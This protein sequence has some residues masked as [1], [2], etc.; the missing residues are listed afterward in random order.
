MLNWI[1]I[2]QSMKMRETSRAADK[3]LQ[4]NNYLEYLIE[5]LHIHGE[6]HPETG[7]K[8]KVK[9]FQFKNVLEIMDPI[10]K[11]VEKK[12]MKPFMIT[13]L[14]TAFERDSIILSPFDETIYKQLID[15]NVQRI[16]QS[17]IPIYT[18]ENEHFVDALALAYLAFVLE[19]P[20]LTNIIKEIE[21]CNKRMV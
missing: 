21:I 5:R 8:N 12:P 18:S 16:S 6:E 3:K 10:N 2:D 1:G 9:G 14:A 15:Y 17:G 19:F 7:L 20:E 4:V 11:E 13:Q